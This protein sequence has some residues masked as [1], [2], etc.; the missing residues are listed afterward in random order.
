MRQKCSLCVFRSSFSR[1]GGL[2]SGVYCIEVITTTTNIN[3]AT[4]TNNNSNTSTTTISLPLLLQQLQLRTASSAHGRL[5]TAVSMEL[6]GTSGA[7]SCG[8]TSESDESGGSP[9]C[10]PSPEMLQRGARL[11]VFVRVRVRVRMCVRVRVRVRVRARVRVCCD[12]HARNTYTHT[13]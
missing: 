7:S 12:N 10:S 5:W 4:N 1:E 13:K 8:D 2:E 9:L 11:L 6:T 3:T